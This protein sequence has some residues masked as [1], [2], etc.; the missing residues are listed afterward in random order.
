M[1]INA[2]PSGFRKNSFEFKMRI[3]IENDE[4]GR[5]K[6]YFVLL[7]ISTGSSLI[8]WFILSFAS[9]T[10]NAPKLIIINSRTTMF[11]HN[12]D[13]KKHWGI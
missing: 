4:R 3:S 13:W 9:N 5:R 12:F 1:K 6:C 11:V 8:L 2:G 10:F 7:F